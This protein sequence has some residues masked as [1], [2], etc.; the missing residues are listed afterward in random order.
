MGIILALIILFGVICLLFWYYDDG[1]SAVICAI[2]L[3]FVGVIVL[4]LIF[5]IS[6]SSYVDTRTFYDATVEQYRGAITMYEDAAALDIKK[7]SFTDFV[8]KD[9]QKNVARM[10]RNLRYEVVKYNEE[11][12][13]KRIMKKNFM[14]NW[15]I[16]APDKDMKIIRLVDKG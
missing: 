1:D 4:S 2:V 15:L 5:G 7:A 8:Y 13:S 9:Y 14:F 11:I 16:I 6:Y 3:S 12:V 10:I